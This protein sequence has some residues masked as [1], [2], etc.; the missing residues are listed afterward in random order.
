[1]FSQ[2]IIAFDIGKTKILAAVVKMRRNGF[3]FLEITE[4]KNPRNAKKIEKILLDYCQAVRQKY[5]AKKVA[6]SAAHLVDS[7]KKTVSQGKICY[8]ADVFSFQFLE[9]NG[10]SVKIEN[11]G[12]C[13]ALGE[14]YLGKGQNTISILTLNLGTEIGGG[15]IINGENYQGAHN[16]ALEVSHI[17]ANY[18][19]Q[20][21]DWAGQCAGKGIENLYR[22]QTGRKI[23]TQT[24]FVE[25]GKGDEA[26]KAVIDKA[27]HNLGM[28]LASLINIFD[29][30]MIIFG[31]SLSKQKKYIDQ[32]VKIAKK[33]VFNKKANYKFAVSSLGNKANLL[34][35]AKFFVKSY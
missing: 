2:K 18:A 22:Q 24:V 20:W 19:G 27:A 8:G 21:N 25:A 12:R 23:S 3:Y 9:N 34:G 1:M 31:G 7:K 35:A 30:E 16:S 28:G 32:A 5:S 33:N 17:S 11:D 29:P 14:Y 26:A 4:F 13:F 6:V 10:F 15:F